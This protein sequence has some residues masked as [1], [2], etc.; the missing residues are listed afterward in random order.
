M[1]AVRR[2][3]EQGED[4][5][6]LVM[7]LTPVYSLGPEWPPL[8]VDQYDNDEVIEKL[9]IHLENRIKTRRTLLNDH[10]KRQT[11]FRELL[12]N[13]EKD[14]VLLKNENKTLKAQLRAENANRSL[15]DQ[16]LAFNDMKQI[17]EN[18]L[19]E[20]ELALNAHQKERIRNKI[21]YKSKIAQEKSKL[22]TEFE[23]RLNAKKREQLHKNNKDRA[24]LNAL[25]NLLDSDATEDTE[26]TENDENNLRT[27]SDPNL[28]QVAH[29]RSTRSSRSRR[30]SSSPRRSIAVSNPKTHRRSRSTDVEKW[31]DHRPKV[32]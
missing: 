8:Q 31:L 27:I 20:K 12:S 32:G 26:D 19:D 30:L 7:D 9:R 10:E 18:E 13:L 16:L 1:E 23:K 15:N 17:L 28:S 11:K 4:V 22:T 6:D 5:R 3:A 24:K 14:S 2:L 29:G 25:K 21:K